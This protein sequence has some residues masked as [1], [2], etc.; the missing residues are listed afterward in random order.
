MAAVVMSRL[1]VSPPSPL[2]AA[3]VT[4]THFRAWKKHLV[5][6]LNQDS[7]C[8]RFLPKGEYQTW[9][10]TEDDLSRILTLAPSDTELRRLQRDLGQ[11]AES[12]ADGKSNLL[13]QRNGQLS[14]FLLLVT[15][16]LPTSFTHDLVCRSTSMDWILKYL[17]TRY[18]VGKQGSNFLNVDDLA[19]SP[20]K[21]YGEFFMEVQEAFADSLAPRGTRIRFLNNETLDR[22]EQLTPIVHNTITWLWLRL[23]DPRLP[24]RIKQLYAKELDKEGYMLRDLQEMICDRLPNILQEMDGMEAANA[25]IRA[26][27]LQDEENPALAAFRTT[28][29]TRNPSRTSRPVRGNQSNKEQR[30]FCRLCYTTGSP[31]AVYTS[32]SIF[33]CRQLSQSDIQ[34]GLA[35]LNVQGASPVVSF[36]PTDEED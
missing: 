23:I 31:S 9:I 36:P 35:Q 17:E 5:L 28:R 15:C 19:Y 34:A 25:A 3:G 6:Y 16:L 1:K 4:A 18:N 8:Q 22:D 11:D 13:K 12:L 20:D 24:K 32:H 21:S 30:K 10:A 29:Q 33:Q 7:E 14:K 27:S 2:P 26:I